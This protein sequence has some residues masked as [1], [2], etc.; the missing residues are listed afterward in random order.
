MSEE[1]A[2]LS[3]NMEKLGE[4]MELSFSKMERKSV[5]LCHECY[6]LLINKSRLLG[7]LKGLSRVGYILLRASKISFLN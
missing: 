2:G 5:P 4:K 7:Q 1:M 3:Y 6:F